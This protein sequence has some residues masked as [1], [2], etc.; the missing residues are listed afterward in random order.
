[1]LAF[2]KLVAQRIREWRTFQ[3]LTQETLGARAGMAP[4]QI[5]KYERE[6]AAPTTPQIERLLAAFGVSGEEFLAGPGDMSRRVAS[7]L[8]LDGDDSETAAREPLRISFEYDLVDVPRVSMEVAAGPGLIADDQVDDCVPFRSDWLVRTFGAFKDHEQ[9]RRRLCVVN[10]AK[11]AKHGASMEPV[12]RRGSLLLVD[13]R[14][15]TPATFVPGKPHLVRREDDGIAVKF[16]SL[17]DG[18]VVCDSAN[19]DRVAY[20]TFTIKLEPGEPL[21][22]RVRGRVVWWA[23]SDFEGYPSAD[24]TWYRGKKRHEIRQPKA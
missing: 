8:Q 2:S 12:I 24:G 13:R 18:M 5:G 16:V 3:D 17:A 1:M 11:D 14:E 6:D 15:L 9:V 4:Q 23:A 19:T 7:N 20:P 21:C 22:S 10:V